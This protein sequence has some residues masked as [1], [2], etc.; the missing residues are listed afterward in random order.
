MKPGSIVF[1]KQ[2]M[3]SFSYRQTLENL[4]NDLPLHNGRSVLYRIIETLTELL[5]N[6]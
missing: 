5:M 1:W 2:G 3:K 6:S 4:E